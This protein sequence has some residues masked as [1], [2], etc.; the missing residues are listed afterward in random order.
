MGKDRYRFFISVELQAR[1]S[2]KELE[3]AAV[4]RI[5]EVSEDTVVLLRK[6]AE[7]TK[8]KYGSK[9]VEIGVVELLQCSDSWDV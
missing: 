7:E 1:D 2:E 3:G 6:V 8:A 9:A 5:H 4:K